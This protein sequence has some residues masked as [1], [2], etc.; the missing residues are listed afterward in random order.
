LLLGICERQVIDRHKKYKE[1]LDGKGPYS[2][3]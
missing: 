1:Y 3:L 2:N